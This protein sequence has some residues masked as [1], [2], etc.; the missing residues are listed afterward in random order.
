VTGALPQAP[1]KELTMLSQY[2]PPCSQDAAP[3]PNL[4]SGYLLTPRRVSTC[5]YSILC[6]LITC[7]ATP[8][9]LVPESGFFYICGWLSQQFGSNA[10]SQIFFGWLTTYTKFGLNPAYSHP[11]A[12]RS[13][14]FCF[15]S[16]KALKLTLLNTVC[17]VTV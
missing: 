15:S 17:T 1:L 16:S 11:V 7:F 6:A 12:L 10:A 8:S 14:T 9:L 13:C 3:N 5:G 4:W 2:A